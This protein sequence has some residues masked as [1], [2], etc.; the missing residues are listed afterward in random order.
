VR[1]FATYERVQQPYPVALAPQQIGLTGERLTQRFGYC[2]DIQP[3]YPERMASAWNGYLAPPNI[4]AVMTTRF[5]YGVYKG[6]QRVGMAPTGGAGPAALQQSLG[7]ILASQV[8]QSPQTARAA[9]SVWGLST[10]ASGG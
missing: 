1:V 3:Q 10:P 7:Q 2:W 6:T 4:Q 5:R 9:L 8:A